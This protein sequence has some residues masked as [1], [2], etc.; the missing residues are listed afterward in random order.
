M[1]LQRQ[2]NPFTCLLTSFGMLIGVD[3]S[4]LINEVGHDGSGELPGHHPQEMLA[5]C[6]ER[7]F[8]ITQYDL[9]PVSKKGDV[10][11]PVWNPGTCQKRFIHLVQHHCCV[12]TGLDPD[13]N[14]HAW[15][16]DKTRVFD[17]LVPSR[18]TKPLEQYQP[19]YLFIAR[20][21]QRP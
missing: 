6:E 11:V 17:P 4:V 21:E 20:A 13:S 2:P 9:I 14:P 18:D 5:L 7:G 16:W 15:A 1:I 10:E 19:Q 3:A 8:A 12:M